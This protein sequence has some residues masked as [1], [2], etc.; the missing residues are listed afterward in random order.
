MSLEVLALRSAARE[1]Y[2]DEAVTILHV[3]R[4]AAL[5]DG[6]GSEQVLFHYLFTL[7]VL[8]FR[9]LRI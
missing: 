2:P 7:V 6:I 5:A 1:A 4:R 9:A 8:L 3:R